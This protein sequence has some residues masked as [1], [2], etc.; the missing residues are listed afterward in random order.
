M[1]P[2][3]DH[4]APR[5]LDGIRIA[6]FSRV[7]AGPYASMMLADLGADVI[8][9]EGPDGDETRHWT[10]PTDASGRS[11][12]FTGVN[13]N[14][15]AITL[16]LR[17]GAG[18]ERARDLAVTADVVIE[19]F[20]PGVMARFALDYDA[21]AAVNPALVYCSI[22]GFGDAAGADLP[23]FD[24]LV[25]AVGGL[26]SVTG[27]PDG[28]PT[29]VGV[30]LVDV[31]TAQNASI[32]ILSALRHRDATGHGQRVD[33]TLLGS[34][35]SALTNI[36]SAALATGEAPG[37]LGNDHPSIVPYASF[38][39]LDGD[40]V[41]AVG[42]DRQFAAL[43]TELGAPEL[44][45]DERFASNPGRVA[46]RESLTATLTALLARHSAGDWHTR[47]SAVGVPVGTVNTVPQ[48][49]ALADA[50]GLEP[51]ISIPDAA[52]TTIANPI[53]LSRTPARYDRS[54]PEPSADTAWTPR[55]IT[56]T[57]ETDPVL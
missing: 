50:L 14:K 25:Q 42:N 7:L 55:P 23:G 11:S 18:L 39:T 49:I 54:A 53:R 19:N 5:A 15:S 24:L 4:L 8:K 57:A 29:K 1:T 56:P 32:G 9:I 2:T 13:R 26:M 47:L 44:A 36:S 21:L 31:L 38:P 22:T 45:A 52:G 6:D 17:E 35:L 10:P 48:A 34:T 27:W 41:I 12:Y 51:V 40:L 28:P 30:A 33:V 46:H 20:R 37:R 43:V 16:D 3:D